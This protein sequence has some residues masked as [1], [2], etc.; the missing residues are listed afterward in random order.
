MRMKIRNHGFIAVM[1]AVMLGLSGCSIKGAEST[2][3]DDASQS[4]QQADIAAAPTNGA[5]G[6]DITRDEFLREYLYNLARYGYGTD[7]D[8]DTLSEMREQVINSLIEDR[9]IR[10]KFAEYGLELSEQDKVDIQAEVDAGVASMLES[11]KSVAKS[12]D[13]TLSDE[14]LTAQAQERYDLILEKCGISKDTFY[15]WQETLFM[16]Q[17]LADV[18]GA[19]AECTDEEVSSQLQALISLAKSQYESSPEEFNGQSYASVWLPEG[20]RTIQAILVGFDYD[21]YS[22]ISELRSAGS[23]EEADALREQSLDGLQ[24]RYEAVMSRIVAGDDFAQLME[25][26][27]EDE[28]NL[29]LIVTPGTEVFGKDIEECAMGIDLPGGTSAA[30]TDYGYYILRYAGDAVVSE[31]TLS[32]SAEEIRQYSLENKKS[33]LFEAEL[34][35]W[36]TEYSYE[37]NNDAI[38]F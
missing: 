8:E 27:D 4:A 32:E 26:F 7:T 2:S 16:K 35:K 23:D 29:T 20:S 5:E 13:E 38:V 25:E 10:A 34:D 30:V 18:I 24:E 12:V 21:T 19:D 9:I 11:I 1:A 3:S 37:I 15:T 6:M 31:E 14:E 36:K 17:R 22:S 28:G 33:K